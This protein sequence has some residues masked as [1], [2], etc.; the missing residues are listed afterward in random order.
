M[1][2]SMKAPKDRHDVICAVPDVGHQ[3]ERDHVVGIASQDETEK[4]FS[5]PTP[6]SAAHF[7]A[8]Q[9]QAPQR[10]PVTMPFT[11]QRPRFA[12]VLPGPF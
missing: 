3:V 5:T 6:A 7:A 4:A 9:A 11:A 10:A 1:V 12:A 8:V 2:Y